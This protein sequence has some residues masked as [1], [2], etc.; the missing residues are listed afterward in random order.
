MYH[1]HELIEVCHGKLNG[2][3]NI[4]SGEKMNK[5]IDDFGDNN[6]YQNTEKQYGDEVN[7][8]AYAGICILTMITI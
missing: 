8:A 5:G 2:V 4:V 1:A 6:V 7:V 3:L